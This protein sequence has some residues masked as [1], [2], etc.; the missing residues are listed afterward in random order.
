[1][2][3]LVLPGPAAA[4]VTAGGRDIDTAKW[5][6][7]A[8]AA[9]TTGEHLQLL[10]ERGEELGLAIADPENARLRMLAMPADGFLKIDGTLLGCGSSGRCA[11]QELGLHR[12]RSC[13]PDRPRRGR[14][15]A[16][17]HVRRAGA[18]RGGLG[19]GEGLRALGKQLAEAMSGL[20]SCRRGRQAARAR[21]RRRRRARVVGARPDNR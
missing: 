19:L 15:P 5:P 7:E 18:S 13:L 10:D 12:R 21:R 14:R 1:M 17:L 20:P 8:T 9:V 3:S 2:K 11:A 16:R 6:A 4:F